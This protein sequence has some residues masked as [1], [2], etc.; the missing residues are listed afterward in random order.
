MCHRTIKSLAWMSDLFKRMGDYMPHKTLVHLPH[1]W[2]KRLVYERMT[3]ELVTQNELP[4]GFI[5]YEHFTRIWQEKLPQFTIP[6]VSMIFVVYDG[7]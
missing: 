2:T 1:T 4:G 6:N 5:S 3:R 7:T